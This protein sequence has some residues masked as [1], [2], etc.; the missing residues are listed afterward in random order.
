MSFEV[1]PP[2]EP[3]KTPTEELVLNVEN[4]I[5][6]ALGQEPAKPFAVD[7]EETE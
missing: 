6:A 2:I 7:V 5:R 4:V 3:G 1:L